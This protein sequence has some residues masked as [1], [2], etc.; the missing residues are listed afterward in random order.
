M[1]RRRALALTALTALAVLALDQF[2]KALVRGGIEQGERHDLV[3]AALRLTHVE[4]DG[5]AFGRLSGSPVLVAFVVGGA[6]LALVL[7]AARHLDVPGIWL[8]TGL[9][10]GGAF[11]NLADRL[12]R[13]HVTDYLKLPS[14][15][16]FNIADVC[17]TLG[18]VILLVVVERDARRRQRVEQSGGAAGTA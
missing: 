9:L 14:W 16:A 2:V 17:I 3:G 7:Y 5:V 12:A 11:G 10:I 18:V 4:N 6:V 15:P 1:A 13:G 8:P